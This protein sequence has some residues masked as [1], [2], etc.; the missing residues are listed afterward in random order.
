MYVAGESQRDDT[1][2]AV[3][4]RRDPSSFTTWSP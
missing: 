2:G 3:L 4:N 1:M